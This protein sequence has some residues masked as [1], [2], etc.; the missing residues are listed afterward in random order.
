MQISTTG[1]ALAVE[2]VKQ[3]FQEHPNPK[4]PDQEIID[5]LKVNLEGNDFVFFEQHYLQTYGTSM[6]KVFAPHY[7][8]IF[9]AYQ[10]K[11]ALATCP[12][13]PVVYLRFLDAIFIIWRVSREQFEVL[14]GILNNHH[15]SIKFK[16]EF[17]DRAVNFFDTT[18]F[19]GNG[20]ANNHILDTQV[21]FKPTDTSELLH[22]DS[23]HPPH[24]LS[25][26]NCQSGLTE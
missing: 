19:K 18:V 4:R 2:A 8:D 20:F 16:A 17:S 26:H 22:I 5:L 24:T 21:Y 13:R 7:A 25:N 10:E 9:M 14:L 23:Y 15:P 6:E 12:I 3:A 11:E 1:I